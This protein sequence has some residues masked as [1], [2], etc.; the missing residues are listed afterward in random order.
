V[1]ECCCGGEIVFTASGD[2]KSSGDVIEGDKDSGY[3][4]DGYEAYK[5]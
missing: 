1:Q 2:V 4:D 5:T 3:I